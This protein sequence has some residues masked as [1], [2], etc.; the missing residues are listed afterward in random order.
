MWS[1]WPADSGIELQDLWVETHKKYA[2]LYT[3]CADGTGFHLATLYS[4]CPPPPTLLPPSPLCPPS[5]APP[6]P[7]PLPRAS[8]PPGGHAHGGGRA[9]ASGP[10]RPPRPH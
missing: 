6:H 5:P 9:E 1:L 2:L 8:G 4:T 3:V 10:V 7:V